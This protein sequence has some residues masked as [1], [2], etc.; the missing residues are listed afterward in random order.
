M[1]HIER[2][3]GHLLER[4]DIVG[5]L[6]VAIVAAWL[7]LDVFNVAP[8]WLVENL[9]QAVLF[10]VGLLAIYL[11]RVL[12]EIRRHLIEGRPAEVII[13]HEEIYEAIINLIQ[14]SPPHARYWATSFCFIHML[15]K[16]Q[17]FLR[18]FEVLRRKLQSDSEAEYRCA[19]AATTRDGWEILKKRNAELLGTNN[20][21]LRYYFENPLVLNCLIGEIEAIIGI[22]D[23]SAFP[24]FGQRFTSV[25]PEW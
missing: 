16:N 11:H 14:R 12:S 13:G 6:S 23:R 4:A 5:W 17:A 2:N 18:Y 8:P 15:K 7:L 9:P 3:L 20:A 19:C 21:E 1:K 22:P 10:V 24:F 25:T